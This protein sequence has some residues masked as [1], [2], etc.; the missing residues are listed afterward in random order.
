MLISSTSSGGRK[1]PQQSQ[2]WA[3]FL[4]KESNSSFPPGFCGLL[5]AHSPD[6]S[7]E[8]GIQR[9]LPH[10]GRGLEQV[11]RVG[12]DERMLQG[13]REDGGQE[14]APQATEPL[15]TPSRFLG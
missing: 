14:E 5:A 4:T 15:W 2:V 7:K 3:G 9:R 1:A 8:D 13:Q 12:H 11:L 10:D 6:T